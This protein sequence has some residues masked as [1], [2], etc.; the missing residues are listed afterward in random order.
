MR[1]DKIKNDVQGVLTQKVRLG[2]FAM[3]LWLLAA[4]LIVRQVRGRRRTAY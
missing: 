4:V 1:L 3:P 2:F